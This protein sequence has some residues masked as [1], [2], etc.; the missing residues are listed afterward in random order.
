MGDLR[1][2]VCP[3]TILV[4]CSRLS[5]SQGQTKKQVSKEN[6]GE[7]KKILEALVPS[8][9]SAP[10]SFFF[11]DFF[12]FRLLAVACPRLSESL[13]QATILVDF[14]TKFY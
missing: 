2:N 7:T 13:E 11:Y 6:E 14:H 9:A 12:V 10:T 4:A 1:E 3:L 8:L 5:D